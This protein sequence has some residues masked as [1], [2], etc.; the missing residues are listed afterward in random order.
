MRPL[1]AVVVILL[2][3]YAAFHRHHYRQR[4]RA[5]F[6]VWESLP[7]PWGTRIRISKRLRPGHLILGFCA[8]VAVVFAVGLALGGH[9]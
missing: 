3:A 6:G 1:I 8:M 9:L 7:G 2:I 4:R 5:G